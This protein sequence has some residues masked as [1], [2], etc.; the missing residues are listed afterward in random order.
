MSFDKRFV[1]AMADYAEKPPIDVGPIDRMTAWAI[2]S[3]LQLASR[4][5]QNTGA[6]T[7]K[8]RD[9]AR[10]LQKTMELDGVLAGIAE[11][12]WDRRFDR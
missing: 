3:Q 11:M 9:F 10:H 2:L 6:M 12:G 5:P 8:A 1:A 7:A 4:H